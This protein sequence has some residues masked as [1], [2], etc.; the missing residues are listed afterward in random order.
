MLQ[1]LKKENNYKCI[2]LDEQAYI[3]RLE[4]KI[5]QKNLKN[6]KNKNS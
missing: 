1:N 2:N 4:K 5:W 6:L 3:K